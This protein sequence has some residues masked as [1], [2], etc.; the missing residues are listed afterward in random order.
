MGD[1]IDIECY[2]C[3]AQSVERRIWDAK[4]R[5]FKSYRVR[6]EMKRYLDKCNTM[7]YNVHRIRDVG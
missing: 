2:L 5:R 6:Q 1:L 7:C 3:I 4:V